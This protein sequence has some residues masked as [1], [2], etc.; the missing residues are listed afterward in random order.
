MNKWTKVGCIL[1]PGSSCR[2]RITSCGFYTHNTLTDKATSMQ[3]QQWYNHNY[4]RVLIAGTMAEIAF[5]LFSQAKDI[6][7]TESRA[8]GRRW[9]WD[10]RE[11]RACS[12][13]RP[14]RTQIVNYWPWFRHRTQEEYGHVLHQTNIRGTL[15]AAVG[16]ELFLILFLRWKYVSPFKMLHFELAIPWVVL[17]IIITSEGMS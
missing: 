16:F 4:C 7:P 11:G 14:T 10:D 6:S 2:K 15:V 5:Y 13:E 17:S 1:L 3:L 9:R 12:T 8:P